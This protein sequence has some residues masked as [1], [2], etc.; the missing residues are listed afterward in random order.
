MSAL[1]FTLITVIAIYIIAE[2]AEPK[3]TVYWY[4]NT[5]LANNQ[6]IYSQNPDVF[7]GFY[8]CCGQFNFDT[9]GSFTYRNDSNLINNINSFKNKVEKIYIVGGISQQALENFNGNIPTSSFI[10]A[11]QYGSSLNIDGFIIDFEP[12]T[13]NIK[14]AQQ[15]NTFL[16]LFQITMI[17]KYPKLSV[18][19]DISDW[20]ILDYYSLYETANLSIYT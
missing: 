12:D 13:T 17:N 8:F 7:S 10:N 4:S 19:M 2:A 5:N 14:L 3:P 11:G 6:R 16:S 1:L 15:Y 9:N 18:N 20:G